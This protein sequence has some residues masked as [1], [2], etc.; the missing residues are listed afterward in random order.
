MA[1]HII[2]LLIVYQVLKRHVNIQMRNVAR[3]A[4][5]NYAHAFQLLKSTLV[6]RAQ[7]KP[8]GARKTTPRAVD[9]RAA[10]WYSLRRSGDHAVPLFLVL[11]RA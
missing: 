6:R 7:E 5:G 8:P 1:H 4:I 9:D 11:A 3:Y 2:S 10:A